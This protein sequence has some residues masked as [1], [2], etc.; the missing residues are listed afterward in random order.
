MVEDWNPYV[1]RYRRDGF[2]AGIRVRATSEAKLVCEQWN[3]LEERE[4]FRAEGYSTTH[5]RH[6]DQQF[7]WDLA[8]D[9]LI[10]DHVEPL[11]GPDILLFGTRFFCK[12]GPDTDYRVSWHQD[13][14][15][16]GLEPPVALTVWYAI[17]AS[18]EEN[19]CMQVIPRSH[20]AP[21]LRGHEISEDSANL[22]GRGQHLW[23]DDDEITTAQ[24]VVLDAGEISI[25]DGALVHA[26]MPNRS[27]RRRCGLALRY[28]PC[29]V[30]QRAD[31]AKSPQAAA[32]LVRGRDREGNFGRHASPFA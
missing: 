29:H 14:D 20:R 22:L 23:L 7:V 12:Y 32:I 11:I 4:G 5:S 2:V 10:L 8:S 17:D 18:D 1:G 19:G 27:L 26:S 3:E 13:L 31:L 15:S 25:H 30:R 28:V 16:W 6:L 9:P 24:P 21:A